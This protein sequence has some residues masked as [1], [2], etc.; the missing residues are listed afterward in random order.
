MHI[1]VKRVYD[2]PDPADGTRVLVDRLWPR[3]LTKN[4]AA[5]DAWWK[6]LAP[7]PDLRQWFDHDPEKFNAFATKYRRELRAHRDAIDAC[8]ADID[9][10]KRLTLLTATRDLRYGHV[11][12]LKAFLDA[13]LVS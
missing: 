13:R 9:K 5:L 10:R 7:S 6:D 11:A 1:A 3:G 4:D 12:P 2:Q 8:L